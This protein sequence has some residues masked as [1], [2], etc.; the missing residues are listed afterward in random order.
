MVADYEE[1]IDEDDESNNIVSTP[2][3]ILEDTCDDN[4][5]NGEETGVDCGGPTCTPCLQLDLIATSVQVRNDVTSVFIGDQ[6]EFEVAYEVVHQDIPSPLSPQLGFYISEDIVLTDDDIFIGELPLLNREVGQH[7]FSF[8]NDFTIPSNSSTGNVFIIM[9]AD[10]E[11]ILGEALTAN[12]IAI[13]TLEI[14]QA[15]C[16]DGM[17]NGEESG[18]DCGGPLCPTCPDI[19]IIASAVEIRNGITSVFRGDEILYRR[20]TGHEMLPELDI[21]NMNGRLYDPRIGR[22]ISVDNYAGIDGTS[23]SYNRYSYV[24]NNPLMYTDPSGEFSVPG[25]MIGAFVGGVAGSYFGGD[26]KSTFGG[27][28]SGGLIGGLGW[29]GLNTVSGAKNAISGYNS[30]RSG[31]NRVRPYSGSKQS[32][33]SFENFTLPYNNDPDPEQEELSP[34]EKLIFLIYHGIQTIGEEATGDV[35]TTPEEY[36][37]N[38]DAGLKTMERTADIAAAPWAFKPKFNKKPKKGPN[39]ATGTISTTSTVPSKTGG[40]RSL[41]GIAKKTQSGYNL[42]KELKALVLEIILLNMEL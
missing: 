26:D 23:Q 42:N 22:M 20:Y 21:I 37:D 34:L 19:D 10:Y 11:G 13:T 38:F 7:S 12:N 4:I 41:F 15:S 16:D 25:A 27:I 14:S 6:I 8:G 1:L 36:Q 39:R 33:N 28:V 5:Q 35:A 9:F 2:L 18:V 40:F 3:E 30:L 24:Q 32:D 31:S 29:S 17:Q